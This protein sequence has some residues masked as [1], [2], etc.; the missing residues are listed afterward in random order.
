V[1]I[2]AQRTVAFRL[3]TFFPPGTQTLLAVEVRLRAGSGPVYAARYLREHGAHGP[4]TTALV[5][6]GPAQ[7]VPVPRVAE[8]PQAAYR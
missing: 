8:D 7:Q 5:L 4:L 1:V 2:P 3:S 6:Q